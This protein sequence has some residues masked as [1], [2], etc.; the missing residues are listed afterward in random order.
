MWSL[1]LISKGDAVSE[2]QKW[3]HTIENQTGLKLKILV[4]DNSKLVLKSINDWCFQFGIIH[5]WT[6]PYISA[7]NGHVECMHQTL[8]NKAHAICLSYNTS[9]TFWDKFCVILAYLTNL[10]PLSSLQSVLHLNYSLTST[11]PWFTYVK[12]D[13]M[14]SPSFRHPIPRYL[15]ALDLAS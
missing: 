5:H 14:L 10:T 15:S 3:H 7:Q 11:Y 12:L 8:L 4:T 9:A 6:A 2:L 13:A 1:P